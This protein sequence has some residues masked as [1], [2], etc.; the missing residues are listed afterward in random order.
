MGSEIDKASLKTFICKLPF[1]I[2]EAVLCN[3]GTIVAGYID[4]LRNAVGKKGT[5]M[6]PL[7]L[8]LMLVDELCSEQDEA[9]K[10]EAKS[11]NSKTD[12]NACQRLLVWRRAQI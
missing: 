6:H 4:C 10:E 1:A 2:C 11:Y 8:E 7:L 5:V 12:L 9:G 3:D